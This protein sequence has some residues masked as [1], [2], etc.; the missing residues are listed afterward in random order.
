MKVTNLKVGMLLYFVGTDNVYAV[1]VNRSGVKERFQLAPWKKIFPL[2]DRFIETIERGSLSDSSIPNEFNSFSYVW[3][4]ELLPPIS[5]LESFNILVIIPSN[6]LNILPFHT[7]WIQ[8]KKQ[9]LGTLFGITYCSCATLF[10]RCVERN[11]IRNSNLASW[12]YSLDKTAYDNAPEAPQRCLGIGVDIIGD[13]TRRYIKLSETFANFFKNPVTF[14]PKPGDTT[15]FPRS[16]RNAIKGRLKGDKRWE[17]I[18]IACHG[19]IDSKVSDNSG[20]LLEKDTFGI[21]V[22]PIELYWGTYFDFRDL[23]FRY[24]PVEIEPSIPAEIMTVGELKVDCFTDS[25]LVALFGCSTGVGEIVSGDEY[26]SIAYQ[27][28]KMGAASV[29]AN[30]WEL[31]IE[32]IEQ[33]A[34]I[35]LEN[36]LQ[37]R[38]PKAIAWQ[39]T[40][41]QILEDQK[42]KEPYEW[43]PI[44]LFGDWL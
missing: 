17:V 33:W 31:D 35:F 42:K 15:P 18:C 40:S 22:R 14:A 25:Q 27:W 30:L 39:Q 8:D 6:V 37:K 19:Y 21:A 38:H 29:L 20:L 13:K 2:I 41:K 44:T 36:W 3:G 43:G 16:T 11:P 5:E 23:P 4:K 34:P 28:L 9:Y 10:T 7:I 1:L 32:F 24:L 26:N 12:E